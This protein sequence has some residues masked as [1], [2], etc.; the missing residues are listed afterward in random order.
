MKNDRTVIEKFSCLLETLMKERAA[1]LR[2]VGNAQAILHKAP[3]V[4]FDHE[5]AARAVA[6]A[7]VVDLMNGSASAD[8][9]AAEFEQQRLQADNAAAA[10]DREQTEARKVLADSNRLVQALTIQAA[11]I[12]SAIRRELAAAAVVAEA[13]A[14]QRLTDSAAAFFNAYVDYKALNCIEHAETRGDG[15][16]QFLFPKLNTDVHLSAPPAV[17]VALPKGCARGYGEEVVY[18]R[19]DMQRLIDARVIELMGDQ[20]GGLYPRV[21]SWLTAQPERL[22]TP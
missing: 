2:E 18:S 11:E 6:Q 16:H 7:R 19:Y 5:A 12:D 1:R 8:K 21:G 4:E 20:S 14:L 15:R 22:G 13:D 17:L 3:P 10:H 9:I